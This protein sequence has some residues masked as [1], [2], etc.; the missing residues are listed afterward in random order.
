VIV[1]CNCSEDAANIQQAIEDM[2]EAGGTIF[3][4]AGIYALAGSIHINRSNVT[5]YGEQGTILRLDDHINQ[6]VILVGSAKNV[7]QAIDTIQNI[8]IADLE[9]DGNKDNQDSEDA[10]DREWIKNNGIDIRAV[11]N[12][13]VDNVNI[14]DARSGGLVVSWNSSRIVISNASFHDNY[15]D[16]IA[17]YTSEDIIVSN[18]ISYGNKSAGISLDN[19][20][21]FVSFNG[22]H[23]RN[24]T[25]EGIFVRNSADINFH[26]L[27][28]EGN[29]QDGAFLANND[30]E[31]ADTGVK[32]IFFQ[33]CSF[34]NNMW[35]GLLLT[36]V[37][38]S[39][40]VNNVLLGCT[41]FGNK[42][43]CFQDDTGTLTTTATICQ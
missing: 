4:R 17:L 37:S 30:Q 33:G 38:P 31:P 13:R 12:L 25:K 6:P 26:D 42:T 5:I 35:K 39:D 8:K 28:I 18:I 3:L 11:M 32:R 9:I 7:P 22:G 14:H 16:G 23:I 1:P 27:M 29:Q 19:E 40:S 36:G 15:Y 34:L 41:F 20:L 43:G 21:K 10:K 2:A 24:N